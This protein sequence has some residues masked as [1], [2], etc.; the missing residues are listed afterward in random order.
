MLCSRRYLPH[1]EHLKVKALQ[2][3]MLE[4]IM[5]MDLE[6]QIPADCPALAQRVF[7]DGA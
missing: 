1:P 7:P 2:G 4:K 3:P 5:C 6:E